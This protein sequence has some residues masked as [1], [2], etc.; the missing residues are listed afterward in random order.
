[1]AT[2]CDRPLVL[3]LSNPTALAEATPEAVLRWTDGRAIVATGS[4]FPPVDH[5]GTR[6]LIGQANNVFVFPGIGL[7]AIV[8]GTRRVTDSMLLAAARALASHTS[9]ERLQ[10][11]AIYPEI[12]VLREVS[13]AIAVAVARDAMRAGDAE[14]R[15]SE[16]LEAEVAAAMWWPAY[17][18]Y[19][20]AGS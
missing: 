8:S 20:R 15:S 3:P 2:T 19:V 18:P 10:A 12:S 1:M 14:D 4:P 17:V 13:H 9:D 11:G 16:A 6:H 5:A 7:G